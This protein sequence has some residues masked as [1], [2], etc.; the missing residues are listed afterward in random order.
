MEE[1]AVDILR[2]I[3]KKKTT[4]PKA[5]L[6]FVARATFELN[7]RGRTRRVSDELYTGERIDTEIALERSNH[8]KTVTVE[9]N[10]AIKVE[11]T[12]KESGKETCDSKL[13]EEKNPMS[14]L[15]LPKYLP[16][17]HKHPQ[18]NIN[19]GTN[20]YEG[21]KADLRIAKKNFRPD[22]ILE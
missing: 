3:L 6:D 5:R 11:G 10:D 16:A 12:E 20:D 13:E 8:T 2:R 1:K 9:K 14:A 7:R 21:T 17:L 4:E 18:P 15:T 19:Y 22:K